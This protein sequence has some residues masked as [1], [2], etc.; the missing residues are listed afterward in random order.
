MEGEESGA[1][2]EI[3][4]RMEIDSSKSRDDEHQK[5]EEEQR[6]G[7]EETDLAC[8]RPGLKF[9]GH[10]HSDLKS[11]KKVSIRPIQLPTSGGLSLF[12]RRERVFGEIDIFEIRQHTHREVANLSNIIAEAVPP[13]GQPL[14]T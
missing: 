8:K 1:E 4:H 5:E 12:S 13:F 7:G 9:F 11:R 10:R 14:R 2:K 6:N 3:V